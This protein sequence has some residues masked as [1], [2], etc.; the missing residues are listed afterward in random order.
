MRNILY[1]FLLVFL[2]SY[3]CKEDNNSIDISGISFNTKL[4]RFDKEYNQITKSNL[5]ELKGKY[6]YFFPENIPDSVWINKQKDSITQVLYH[7]SQA[8]FGDFKK[9]KKEIENVFKHVK[10][11]YPKI[12]EPKLI[13]LISNLD[14]ENQVIYTDSLL[15][16]S[17]DTY[18]GADKI[19]YSNYPSYL[20]SNFN[21]SHLTIDVAQAITNKLIPHISY[22]LFIERIIAAGKEKYSI[23]QFIPTKTEA[24]FMG[25]TD[26]ELRWVNN[27]EESIWK[28][29]IEKE[30]LFSTDKELQR[31]FIDPAPFSKFYLTNDNETPGQIGVW[32]G[33]RIVKSFMKYNEVSLQEMLV[34]PPI[35]IFNKSKYKPNQ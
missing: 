31:R 14:L 24:E 33:Y 7:V 26:E 16:I 2:I 22:R 19:Y 3:S 35:T 20:R 6:P 15:I 27:E 17:I 10:H 11:F 13:T 21:K 23:S 18:L 5:K 9:E 29:F 12:E 32:L 28:Y 25:Y 4:E 1:L 30:Y 34:T 8:S